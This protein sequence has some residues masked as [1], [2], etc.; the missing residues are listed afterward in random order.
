[1]IS[2]ILLGWVVF[3]TIFYV[4]VYFEYAYFYFNLPRKFR[5]LLEAFTEESDEEE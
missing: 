1:M 3:L 4:A 2:Y 5:L